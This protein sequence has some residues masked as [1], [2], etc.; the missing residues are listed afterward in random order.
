MSK[1]ASP[2][3][4]TIAQ[5][6]KLCNAKVASSAG[7]AAVRIGGMAGDDRTVSEKWV[8]DIICKQAGLSIAEY[9]L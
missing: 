3:P 8:F 5:L 4:G 9:V 2:S 1:L 6:L 7:S